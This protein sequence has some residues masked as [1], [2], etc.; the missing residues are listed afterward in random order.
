MTWDS[1]GIWLGAV[2][3][4]IVGM[5]VGQVR[6]PGSGPTVFVLLLV[7]GLFAAAAGHMGTTKIPVGPMFMSGG[8]LLFG[9]GLGLV[10]PSLVARPRRGHDQTPQGTP[11][12]PPTKEA[13]KHE[14]AESKATPEPAGRAVG[15]S[16][17]SAAVGASDKADEAAGI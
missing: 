13:Q 7:A 5:T 16:T 15:A 11:Q 14:G 17:E 9:I 8:L 12:N 2:A 3:I 4:L 1:G 10:V 6:R